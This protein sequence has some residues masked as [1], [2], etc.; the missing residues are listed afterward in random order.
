MRSL[1]VQGRRVG[2]SHVFI[3]GLDSGPSS[4]HWDLELRLE[5]LHTS[6]QMIVMAGRSDQFVIR[7]RFRVLIILFAQ[8]MRRLERIVLGAAPVL[9]LVHVDRSEG[10]VSI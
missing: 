8:V 3:G 9:D 7:T 10:L 6:S 2:V 4:P 5:S 1:L